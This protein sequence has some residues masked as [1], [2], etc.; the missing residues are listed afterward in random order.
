MLRSFKTAF[1]PVLCFGALTACSNTGGFPGT[2][3]TTSSINQQ[4]AA[5]KPTVDPVCVTLVSKIDSL[6]K[7]GITDRVAKAGAGKSKTVPV[8]RTSLARMAELDRANAEY[9]R[10]CGTLKPA[11]A[12]AAVQ[13]PTP[14]VAKTTAPKKTVKKTAAASPAKP[15][16]ANNTAAKPK[17]V[18][19]QA[20]AKAKATAAVAVATPAKPETSAAT[21]EAAKKAAEEAAKKAA[22]E[23]AKKEA[24]KAAATSTSQ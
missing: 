4:Q 5:K 22:L 23:A 9:Q 13:S 7:D 20:T 21:T 10:R 1:V 16:A 19:N 2:S 12:T 15:T 18:T 8:Y 14:P 17:V 3:L 6:R 11:T 24:I